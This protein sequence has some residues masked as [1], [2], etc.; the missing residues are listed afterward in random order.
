MKLSTIVPLAAIAVTSNV[1]A[2]DLLPLESF[3]EW[4][5]TSMVRET[6]I[7]STSEFSLAP[8]NV[9]AE[10]I[11]DIALLDSAEGTWYYNIDIGT[12]APVECYVFNEYD[13]A[14]NS[15]HAI[16][17]LSLEGAA[18]LNGRALTGRYNYAVD[19]GVVGRTPY[20]SLDTL[21]HVGEGE[22]KASGVI[23]ALSA[24]TEN[25]LQVC[26]HSD[27]GY[28]KA[29]FDTFASFVSAFEKSTENNAFF[30]SV[31][32][33]R[34]N[35]IPMGYASERYTKDADGDVV[36]QSSTALLVPVDA[37]AVSRTDSADIS[38]S[39]P[40]GSL[41]N[42]S[43]YTIENGE[44]V[45]KF[46]IKSND[47]KWHVEGSIQGKAVEA[48]LEYEGWLLSD[49]GSYLQTAN[50]Q[51]SEKQSAQFYMWAPDV[52]PVTAMNITLRQVSDKKDTNMAIDMGPMKLDFYA[53]EHGIFKHGV[54]AQGPVNVYMTS[55][56][57]QGIPSL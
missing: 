53:Q 33:M 21:Y 55:I 35:D 30:Q 22:N 14:A 8:F 4:F 41:I 38:W 7:T 39:R 44:M 54:M 47:A 42:G 27:V 37:S 51:E 57:S 24:E 16:V 43:T 5:Q 52:D 31:Y 48:Q 29:F 36:I 20:L 12:N 15:M 46:A 32:E 1:T 17:G 2:K 45:S 6:T 40:D 28:R 56:Y 13:G 34:I 50:L 11:G 49:F 3:P 19:T 23:K 9:K 10:V 26:V 25:S 18:E